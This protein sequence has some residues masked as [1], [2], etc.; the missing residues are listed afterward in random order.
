[1]MNN[2]FKTRT[3]SNHYTINY[4]HGIHNLMSLNLKRFSCIIASYYIS[5]KKKKI[6][7]PLIVAVRL[8]LYKM[9]NSPNTLPDVIVLRYL[10]SL[11]TSTRP[12]KNI[13]KFY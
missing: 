8:Q 1:M 11:L 12:S 4:I 7:I 5:I 2:I 3:I 9:A 6:C 10:F 13:N